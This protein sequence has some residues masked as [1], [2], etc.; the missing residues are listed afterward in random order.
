MTS[1]ERIAALPDVPTVAES[2]YPGYEVTTWYSIMVPAGTPADIVDRLNLELVRVIALPD[3]RERLGAIGMIPE[4]ST[5]QQL[6]AY[7]RQEVARWG[8]IV[9][10]AGISQP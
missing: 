2:G 10:S 3:V 7:I 8:P 5:A 1:S 4:S 6:G 9:K